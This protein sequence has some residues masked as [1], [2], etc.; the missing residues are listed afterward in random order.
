[1]NLRVVLKNVDWVR[2]LLVTKVTSKAQLNSQY[3]LKGA[4]RDS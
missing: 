4:Y 3:V 1:M 2:A